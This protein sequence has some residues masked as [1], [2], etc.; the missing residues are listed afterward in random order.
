[1]LIISFNWAGNCSFLF[2]M[3][4]T[5]HNS[6]LYLSQSLSLPLRL[7]IHC[8]KESVRDREI[9]WVGNWRRHI[10]KLHILVLI[11]NIVYLKKVSLFDLM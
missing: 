9:Q 10:Y 6:C 11:Y 3:L 2:N 1:M 7:Y 4:A 8:S 5:K